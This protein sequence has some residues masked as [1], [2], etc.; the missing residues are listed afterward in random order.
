M[1]LSPWTTQ[2]GKTICNSIRLFW[3]FLRTSSPRLPKRRLHLGQKSLAKLMIFMNKQ[4][5]AYGPA[6][7]PMEAHEFAQ[8][9]LILSAQFRG[10]IN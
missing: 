6:P 5:L 9:V 1:A 10:E 8:K 4:L 2:M 3:I 7:D